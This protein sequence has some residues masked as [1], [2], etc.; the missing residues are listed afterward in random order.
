MGKTILAVGSGVIHPSMEEIG[1]SETTY[2]ELTTDPNSCHPVPLFE[3][4]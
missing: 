3:N 2:D 4:M 1:A